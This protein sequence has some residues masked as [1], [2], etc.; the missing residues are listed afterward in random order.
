MEGSFWVDLLRNIFGFLDGIIYNFVDDVYN[1]F[2]NIA[3]YSIMSDSMVETFTH[4][5]YILVGVL[6]LFKMAFSLLNYFIDPDKI[7]DSKAGFGN[8]VQRTVIS[9]TL[10]VLVPWIFK[11]AL[12][13]QSIILNQNI[14][15]NIILGGTY[16][17]KNAKGEVEDKLTNADFQD[18]YNNAGNLMAFSV[19]GAFISP[20]DPGVIDM[21]EEELKKEYED[22]EKAIESYKKY[23]AAYKEHD[24]N[25]L[26]GWVNGVKNNEDQDGYYL[27]NYTAGISTI[28]G[29]VVVCLLLVFC[30]DVGVRLVKLAFLELI[31][32]IPVI[33]YIDVSK[34]KDI[35]DKWVKECI[36]TYLSVF[37][38][39]IAIYF[40]IYI[41][42]LI[43]HNGFTVY[44]YVLTEAGI[45]TR[46]VKDVGNLAKA[47]IIIG[48]LSFAA[49]TPKL[50]ESMFGIK[51]GDFTLNPIKRL[52]Q[53]PIVG[54][55]AT[56]GIM[57]GGYLAGSAAKFAAKGAK[58][59]MSYN[60][61]D[62]DMA[63]MQKRN[64]EA[65]SKFK[66]RS[67]SAGVNALGRIK[68]G[69]LR[70]SKDGYKGDRMRD[71]TRRAE[72]GN[73]AYKGGFS[74]RIENMQSKLQGQIAYSTPKQ[75]DTPGVKNAKVAGFRMNN[76]MENIKNQVQGLRNDLSSDND[77]RR[78]AAQSALNIPFDWDNKS[79]AT[80]I[81]NELNIQY[82]HNIDTKDM[83]NFTPKAVED[84][85]ALLNNMIN[86][87]QINY[88][89]AEQVAN[90]FSG[91]ISDQT[92]NE[93]KKMAQDK[94]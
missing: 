81:L 55:V 1:T 32:P 20:T 75:E 65:F 92:T 48:L 43:T 67:F 74:G 52:G 42:T 12:Y 70:G 47:L 10:L 39:L 33:S 19:L 34:G 3:N 14:L 6:M 13:G 87:N 9:L 86:S 50:F 79:K 73:P 7:K 29:V 90:F 85:G 31:A 53:V 91:K 68:D 4:R 24:I 83:N 21:T 63:E 57:A 66:I 36:S 15:A 22:D 88:G 11:V 41:I 46:A 94:K 16:E 59:L 27:Y 61:G 18:S 49:E 5:I 62:I 38:R 64:Q 60:R 40:V 2:T 8:L 51:T 26:V 84:L 76:I 17:I 89:Q 77:A 45:Q 78:Q 30:I 72:T 44:T 37:I 71:I 93:Q 54:G 82:G 69:G 28:A 23:K 58:N 35:F 56:A 80:E 25:A